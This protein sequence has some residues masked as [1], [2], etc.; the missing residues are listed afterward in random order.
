MGKNTIFPIFAL[1]V[2]FIFPNIVSAAPSIAPPPTGDLDPGTTKLVT[3]DGLEANKTYAWTAKKKTCASFCLFADPYST[4]VTTCYES[5]SSGQITK[6]LGPFSNP[7]L[8]RLDIYKATANNNVCIPAGDSIISQEFSVGGPT[9]TS[10][11]DSISGAPF[12][13][14]NKDGCYQDP[15][16]WNDSAITNKKPTNCEG[17]KTFCEPESLQCFKKKTPLISGKICIYKEYPDFEEKKKDTKKY[18]ECSLGGGKIIP[19]CGVKDN[20]GKEDPRGPGIPTAIGCIHT[21]PA[22]LAKDLLT[23]VIGIGGGLAFLMM[24]MGAF[25]M[26]TSAGNPETLN[27]GRDRLTSAVI[28]LLFV[29]FSILLLQII[30]V[31]ILNL[32]G[33]K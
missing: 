16:A 15:N 14:R 13:D 22:E 19:G 3:V 2:F 5:N 28:G 20:Q 8:Y 29:I 17:E 31:G 23:W 7:G 25:Q 4:I 10:C 11:C 6:E 32:P 27:A 24:L 33:F 30:G 26:L 21:N 1:I 12:Y 18:T 9:K